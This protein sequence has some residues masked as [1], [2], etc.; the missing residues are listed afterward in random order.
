MTTRMVLLPEEIGRSVMNSNEMCDQGRWGV[1]NGISLPA[2]KVL[3]TLSWAQVLH[4]VTAWWISW[5]IRGHQYLPLIRCWTPGCPVP[6]E[7]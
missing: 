6:V 1:G 3:G 2:V 5:N 7:V 4:E